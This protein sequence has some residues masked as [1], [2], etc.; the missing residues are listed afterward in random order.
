DLAGDYNLSVTGVY[1]FN[2]YIPK[3]IQEM[4][5][6][7]ADTYRR[8][9]VYVFVGEHI[10][11]V[12]FVRCLQQRR[13]LEQGD[14]VVISVDDEIYDPDHKRSIVQREYLDPFIHQGGAELKGFRSVLKL[15][16]VPPQEPPL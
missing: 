16:P 2:N 3:D 7:V 10:A 15:D 11:L 13:L 9:R 4:E 5:K 12:D 6:I 8:T 14:Y 1:E